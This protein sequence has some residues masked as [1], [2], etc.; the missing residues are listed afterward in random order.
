[1]IFDQAEALELRTVDVWGECMSLVAECALIGCTG[2][3][4]KLADA[5]LAAEFQPP[6]QASRAPMSR[7]GW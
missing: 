3:G 1:M 7:P 4:T 5:Q 2:I 6:S